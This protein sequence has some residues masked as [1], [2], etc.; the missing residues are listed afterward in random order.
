MK[1]KDG[2]YKINKSEVIGKPTE[3]LTDRLYETFVETLTNVE[4]SKLLTQS[5]KITEL[6][7]KLY[8]RKIYQ[9]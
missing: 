6:K 1:K 4:K 5:D 2:I 3:D 7:K 9:C 8:K